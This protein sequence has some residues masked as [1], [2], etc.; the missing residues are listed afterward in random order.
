MRAFLSLIYVV[1]VGACVTWIYTS[2]KRVHEPVSITKAV[3]PGY[4]KAKLP[5]EDD[6]SWQ[7]KANGAMAVAEAE[8]KAEAAKTDG[9]SAPKAPS[10]STAV[11][12]KDKPSFA[13]K[14]LKNTKKWFA[15]LGKKKSTKVARAKSKTTKNWKVVQRK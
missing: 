15:N 13:A 9:I 6:A 5:K 1:A 2:Y 14:L 4:Q 12:K 10:T 3:P 7:E 8:A 11:E